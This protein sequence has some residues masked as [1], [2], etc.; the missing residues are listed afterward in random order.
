MIFRRFRKRSKPQFSAIRFD[1]SPDQAAAIVQLDSCFIRK[2][3]DR[4]LIIE[5]YFPDQQPRVLNR[6]DWL[7]KT[8]FGEWLVLSNTVFTEIFE[9]TA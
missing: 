9:E 6:G 5:V 7:V 1:G 2:V 4:G 8:R 3:D